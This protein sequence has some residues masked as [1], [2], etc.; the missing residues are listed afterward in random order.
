MFYRSCG[1][2]ANSINNMADIFA[3][4]VALADGIISVLVDN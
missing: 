2:I 4:I 1:V 3:V